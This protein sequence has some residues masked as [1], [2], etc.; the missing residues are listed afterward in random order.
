MGHLAASTFVEMRKHPR[1]QLRMPARLR[2]R[3]P[4]GMRMET[5]RTIDIARGGIRIPRSESCEVGS[6]VWVTFPFDAN[7]SATVQPETPAHVVRVEQNAQR[8][9]DVSLQLELPQR[10]ADPA[11]EKE[12]RK[13]SRMAFAVPIFVRASGSPWP[14]E[15]MTHDISRS[16]ARFESAH[17][18]SK[19]DA[20][21]ATIPWGEWEHIGEIRARVVRVEANPVSPGPAPRSNPAAGLSG[22]LTAVSVRWDAAPKA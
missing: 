22:M 13:C 21:L 3:G 7:T 6:R 18:Y 20:V 11:R 19:G 9:Y 14:E 16:G 17:I 2:W 10:G 12:R 5:T 15:S 8:G 1:A 4:L